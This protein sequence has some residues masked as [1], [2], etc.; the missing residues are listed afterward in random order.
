MVNNAEL[1]SLPTSDTYYFDFEQPGEGYPFDYIQLSDMW[2][3][4]PVQLI[5]KT[6]DGEWILVKGQ[7][8]L[9]WVLAKTVATV[10]QEFI[11]QWRQKKN[12]AMP[13]FRG[14]CDNFYD[15]FII[16]T[17]RKQNILIKSTPT[18]G[19]PSAVSKAHIL[20]I[21]SILPRSKDAI[22]FPIKKQD[23]TAEIVKVYTEG[24]AFT[25]WPLETNVYNFKQQINALNGMPFSW[26]G[27]D[28]HNDASGLL[29]RLF[30]SFGIWLPR[31]STW[32]AKYAGK[33]YSLP[34]SANDR[35][36]I[37]LGDNDLTTN[38]YAVNIE[39]KPFT[40]LVSFGNKQNSV[41]YIALY[42]GNAEIGDNAKKTPLM[43][44]TPWGLKITKDN[45][46]TAIGRAFVGQSLISPIGIGESV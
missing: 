9:G 30:I 26:G 31:A 21:G 13:C 33:E 44:H 32:Q 41:S 23:G 25:K 34:E 7:G 29:R 22:L 11:D 14:Q 42:I 1:H 19:S 12:S 8:I 24:L 36:N 10:N 27:K 45:D 20:Q 17:V 18:A 39:P 38:R 5:H 4:T 28:F 2:L 15:K 16:P 46:G 40:T 35:K 37:F 43:F 3:G 6:Q